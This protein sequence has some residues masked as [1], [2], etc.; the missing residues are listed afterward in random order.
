M[1]KLLVYIEFDQPFCA[2]T[3][4]SAPCTATGSPKCYNSVLTCRD[5]ANYIDAPVTLRFAKRGV[6][7]LP[8]NIEAIQ[9]IDNWSVSPSIISLGEDLGLRAELRVTL[10][11]HPWPDTGPGGDPYIADRSYTPFNQGTFWGKWRSR[12]RYMRGRPIRLIKGYL[13]Q[14]LSEMET[15]HFV[16]ESVDGPSP[17]GSVTI[18]AKDPLKL[19]DGD[20]AQAPVLSKGYLQAEITNSATS[21]TL[22]PAGI[23]NGEYPTSGFVAIGGA[24]ICAFTRSG[25]TLTLTRAQLGTEAKAHDAEDR[26]QVVLRYVGQD[27]A[28]IIRD[29]FVTY[30][31]IDPDYIDLTDWQAETGANLGRVFSANIAEPTDVSKLVSELIQQAALSIWWDEIDRKI[32]LRVLRQISTDAQTFTTETMMQGSFR[33]REQTDKRVS[34]VWTWYGQRNPLKKVDDQENYKSVVVEVDANA[35]E[36]YGVPAIKKIFS[37]WIAAFGRASA[38]RTGK[39]ILGR[40]RDPPRRFNFALHDMQAAD[41]KAGQG[42]QVEFWNLQN[43]EGAV[44]P[45]PIQITRFE[46]GPGVV[47]IEAEEMLFSRLDPVDLENRSITIDTNTTNFNLRNVHDSL[48]PAPQSGDDFSLTVYVQSGAIVGG[49]VLGSPAFDVG[50][51]TGFGDVVITIIINGRIQGRGGA[52]GAGHTTDLP[53]DGGTIG[54]PGEAGSTAFYTRRAV[55]VENNGEIWGGGGGGGAGG[56]ATWA[57]NRESGGGGGGAG[58]RPGDGGTTFDGTKNFQPSTA[59]TTELGGVGG[60]GANGANN[61]GGDGGGPATAGSAGV[62]GSNDPGKAGGAAGKAVDGDSFVTWAALGDIKGVRDN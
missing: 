13:G 47:G 37:R 8:S 29:L 4:G 3:F 53:A 44:A 20:R 17:D 57:S 48:Y 35:E 58:Y 56:R 46:P 30:A 28:V 14:A 9:S 7:Y 43:S 22:A 52:G 5:R 6:S 12:V 55:T 38:E 34:Q 62:G 54:Q 24:E 59:G 26:V 18:I 36:D 61:K 15:R 41:V 31:G 50:D 10:K 60:Y 39:V 23:G 40:Y 51:W 27:P 19:A 21:A 11:D 49:S 1:S 45:V 16:I 32:R 33:S 25:D 42:Y 2:N